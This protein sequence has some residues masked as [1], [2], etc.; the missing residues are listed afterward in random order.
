M[1]KIYSIEEEVIGMK[2]K[3]KILIL[4]WVS[5][6][7]G[8]FV[9]ISYY[10]QQQ[11][12]DQIE[13]NIAELEKK[14]EEDSISLKEEWQA[15]DKTNP[16]EISDYFRSE[17]FSLYFIYFLDYHEYIQKTEKGSLEGTF[18]TQAYENAL[19]MIQFLVLTS[20]DPGMQEWDCSRMEETNEGGE[21]CVM[22][23]N[24]FRSEDGN[25]IWEE[26]VDSEDYAVFFD[27][28]YH[29][30]ETKQEM[31][32]QQTYQQILDYKERT[33]SGNL[34]QRVLSESYAYLA[35]IAYRNYYTHKG[36]NDFVKAIMD[37]EIIYSVN[38]GFHN[39]SE[40]NVASYVYSAPLSTGVVHIHSSIL[41]ISLV[42]IFPT[43]VV[44]AAWIVLN[45]LEKRD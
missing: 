3:K 7:L 21:Y 38:F 35:E 45:K 28:I 27:E 10:R 23:S 17:L 36:Q 11:F 32:L 34:Y 37:A 16:V 19:L 15:L 29:S 31:T 41:D 26:F 2:R 6:L 9:S 40:A 42:F 4:V 33:S 20:P 39:L 5:L 12:Q 22:L 25:L 14:I 24:Y 8:G 44:V 18:Q 13:R 30:L 43:C 1:L